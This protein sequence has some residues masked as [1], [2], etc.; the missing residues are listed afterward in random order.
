[1]HIPALSLDLNPTETLWE[2]FAR[3]VYDK[4]RQFPMVQILKLVFE[5]KRFF[6]SQNLYKLL[7]YV[8]LMKF[9]KFKTNRLRYV[10]VKRKTTYL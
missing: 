8:C 3:D 9:L 5:R 7:F 1:M 6:Y 2:R 4:W 10:G